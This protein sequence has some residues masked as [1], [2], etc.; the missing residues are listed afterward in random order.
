MKLFNNSVTRALW[1]IVRKVILRKMTF[2]IVFPL[3]TFVVGVICSRTVLNGIIQTGTSW[4]HSANGAFE[5]VGIAYRID[6]PDY[7]PPRATQIE[8]KSEVDFEL[9]DASLLPDRDSLPTEDSSPYVLTDDM[10]SKAGDKRIQ[11]MITGIL[12]AVWKTESSGEMFAIGDTGLEH[13]AYGPLQV[14][15]PVCDDLERLFGVVIDPADCNGDWNLSEY[16]YRLY[17][18]YWG[19]QYEKQS[20]KTA[21]PAIL[22]RIWNGGPTGHSKTATVK[23]VEKLKGFQ[24]DLTSN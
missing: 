5:S 10:M 4:A 22:A 12:P 13:V 3:M 8:E 6:L 24:A 7:S 23:Y 19:S 20:G 15:Q 14:R 11:D 9:M 21:T 18:G 17:V 1:C 2:H 16:A